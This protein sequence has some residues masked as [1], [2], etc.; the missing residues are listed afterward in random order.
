MTIISSQHHID[1]NIVE[2]KM[3][4]LSGQ[5]F[6][7][8]PCYEIGEID[9]EEYAIQADG[10]HTMTAARELGIEVRFSFSPDPE[11]LTGEA[12]LD[13]RWNDGDWY[14]VE[15]SNPGC[16]EFDLIW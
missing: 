13:A 9:G 4:E 11:S 10:H 12:A 14:N 8:I 6:V 7:E 2:H 3:E 1:W 15:T 16:E 5:A